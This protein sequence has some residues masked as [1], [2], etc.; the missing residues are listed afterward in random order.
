MTSEE[1]LQK[2]KEL[3]ETIGRMYDKK[4]FQPIAGRI[5]GLLMVMDKEQFTFDEITAELSISK[6]SASNVLRN[7]EIRGVIEYI[8]V[9]GDRKRYY[10][11][12]KRDSSEM[13]E[14]V[15]RG[16]EEQK[17]VFEDIINLKSD[18]NSAN[19][20]YFR[21]MMYMLDHYLEYI[22]VKKAK[23]KQ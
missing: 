23:Q 22:Q 5:L 11:I 10:Q 14:E 15:I 7:L 16:I 3:I 20:M 12:K 19:S 1:R 17:M 18:T 21:E 13:I 8:T 4:G 6:S 9:P 2:Q